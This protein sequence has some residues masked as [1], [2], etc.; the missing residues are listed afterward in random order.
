MSKYSSC[1]VIFSASPTPCVLLGYCVPV[2]LARALCRPDRARIAR[3]RS[4]RQAHIHPA[5]PPRSKFLRTFSEP[6]TPALWGRA[7]C[8]RGVACRA[9]HSFGVFLLCLLAPFVAPPP[10]SARALLP[11]RHKSIFIPGIMRSKSP[12]K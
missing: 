12:V 4:V 2:A 11:S 7:S 1:V 8:L 6:R 5:H 10:R 3:S 9:P